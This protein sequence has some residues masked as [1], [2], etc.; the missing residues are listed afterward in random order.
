MKPIILVLM[1]I[2]IILVAAPSE[3]EAVPPAWFVAVAAKA[4]WKL[5]KRAYY[6]RCNVRLDEISILLFIVNISK[7]LTTSVKFNFVL[8]I[9][10]I[11][12]KHLLDTIAQNLLLVQECPGA[13]R[14]TL[15]DFMQAQLDILL[16]DNI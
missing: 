8:N 15:H 12:G 11:I 2:S 16:A 3:T 6:A 9:Y 4:G 7:L 10:Y 14:K 1:T 13:L 5:V